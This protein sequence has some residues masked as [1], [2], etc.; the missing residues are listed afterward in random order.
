MTETCIV[1]INLQGSTKRESTGVLLPNIEIKVCEE[2]STDGIGKGLNETGE[3]WIRGPNVMKGYF[4]A[5]EATANM[6]NEDGWLKTGDAGHFDEQGYVFLT[7]RF[8]DLIKVKGFQVAAAE[9]EEILLSHDDVADAAVVGMPDKRTGETPIAVVVLK[10]KGKVKEGD[11]IEMVAEL[12]TEYKQL[13]DVVYVKQIP[14]N[15]TGK[16]LRAQ[17]KADLKQHYSAKSSG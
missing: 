14:R 4:D 10:A 1:T 12:V 5:P 2:N 9:L 3:L 7:G 17:I 16:I 6:I 8:K 15:A 11:L 13:G